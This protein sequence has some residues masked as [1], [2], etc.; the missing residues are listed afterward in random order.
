MTRRPKIA[1]VDLLCS[2]LL[3]IL[4]LIAPP[5][6]PAHKAIDTFGAYAIV[7][8]WPPGNDD[9]DLYLRVPTGA[10]VYFANQEVQ[11]AA[12]ERDDVGILND[13]GVN[14]NGERVIVR[15]ASTGEHI[16]NVHAYRITRPVTVTARFYRIAGADKLLRTQTVELHATGSERTLFRFTTNQQGMVTGYSTL[17]RRLVRPP[18]IR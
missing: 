4:V 13:Q 7:I 2:L 1:A 6:E 10:V 11:G 12:L 15:R 5:P 17:S 9:V 14:A 18:P 16:V 8:T 3:V